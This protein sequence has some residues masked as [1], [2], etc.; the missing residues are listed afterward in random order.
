M[1]FEGLKSDKAHLISAALAELQEM[2]EVETAVLCTADGLAVNGQVPEQ[3]AAVA[4]F[5][6]VSAQQASAILGR[7]H[8]AEEINIRMGNNSTL[9]CWPFTAG[10]VS[11]II[12][13]IFTQDIPYKRLLKQISQ[14][15]QHAV[16][17]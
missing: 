17:G 15:I 11:L 10:E 7:K 6:V 13:V 5:L 8:G 16:R 14:E 2:P 12:A 9:I 1:I 3:I 4:S